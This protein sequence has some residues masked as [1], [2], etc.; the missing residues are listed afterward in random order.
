MG[1]N[2]KARRAAKAKARTRRPQPGS[3]SPFG[4]PGGGSSRSAPDH[5]AIAAVRWWSLIDQMGKVGFD[6][7]K[8]ADALA[9]L[10]ADIADRVGET[11]LYEQLETLWKNGWQPLEVRRQA[12]R[13]CSPATARMVELAI[14]ADRDRRAGQREDPRWTQQFDE[15]GQRDV[16]TRDGWLSG[17]A[18]RE[19][20][21]RSSAYREVAAALVGIS[22]VPALDVLIPPPGADPKADF[23]APAASDGD[24][25]PV[26]RRIRKLLTKA[27]ATEFEDEAAALSAKAQALMTRHAVDQAMVDRPDPGD[28]PRMIRVPVDAP[29]ADAKALLLAVVARASRCRAISIGNL[30]IS[31]VVGHAGDLRGVEMLFTS[32]LVQSQHA[33]AEASR[34]ARPGTRVRSQ[35]YRTSFYR[36][37]TD[38]IAERLERANEAVFDEVRTQEG[39]TAF[40][41]ALR[42][43]EDA[44]EDFIKERYG[45]LGTFGVRGGYDPAG[46]EHGR[47][48]ADEARFGAGVL[49]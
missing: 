14:L 33:L 10:P 43:R 4:T 17:W 49:E 40:L 44:V 45:E 31:S 2:N 1:K 37:F 7:R 25:D 27:E 8:D 28:V 23:Y 22:H 5:Q 47:R 32:L 46:W 19:G 9:R 30:G 34:H 39:S 29:Y 6:L 15:F 20:L 41:P 16:S 48:V 24:S 3:S 21:D 11:L 38:R 13:A 36:A 12:R 18:Q 26:L 42:A 35:S